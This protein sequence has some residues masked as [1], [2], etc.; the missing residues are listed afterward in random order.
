MYFENNSGDKGM[1]WLRTGLT[2]MLVTD[3][4]QSPASRCRHRSPLPD[5][6]GMRRDDKV[7]SPDVISEVARRAGVKHVMLGSYL[8]AGEAIRINLKLQEASTGKILSTERV[9][10]PN[11]AS[12]FPMMDDLT[13]RLK[14]QFAGARRRAR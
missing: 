13:R 14:T 6:G 3:L 10:A 1:D 9:D 8:K 5:P 2:D 11:E 7:V 12:L 4:S